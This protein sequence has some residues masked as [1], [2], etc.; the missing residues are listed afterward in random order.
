MDRKRIA[1]R[2]HYTSA[3]LNDLVH[4]LV[5]GRRVVFVELIGGLAMGGVSGVFEQ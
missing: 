1:R 4:R 3:R 5:L 2:F